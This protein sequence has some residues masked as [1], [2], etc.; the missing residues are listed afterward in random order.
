M[1]EPGKIGIAISSHCPKGGFVWLHP[2]TGKKLLV[3]TTCKTWSCLGCRD[4]KK[5]EVLNKI[6][7]GCHVLK[8]CWLIT[9][10]LRKGSE[11]PKTAAFV[12]RSWRSLMMRLRRWDPLLA[13]RLAWFKVVELTENDQPHLHLIVSGIDPDEEARAD[14]FSVGNGQTRTQEDSQ[15]AAIWSHFWEEVTKDSYVVDVVRVWGPR[16][17]AGY[18]SKYLIKDMFQRE[19]KEELGFIRRFSS[20][21]RWPHE[22]G[23]FTG[24]LQGVW[25]RVDFLYRTGPTIVEQGQLRDVQDVIEESSRSPL[26]TRVSDVV[27]SRMAALATIKR[28]RKK[29]TSYMKGITIE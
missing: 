16:G 25:S 29:F 3:P 23:G 27:G 2:Q 14:V 20:S 5:T 12:E 24:T 21:R 6:E 13:N 28:D 19:K 15:I 8:A 9:L 1:T 26:L 4:R 22:K 10:T 18:L 7:Y 17:A 11:E